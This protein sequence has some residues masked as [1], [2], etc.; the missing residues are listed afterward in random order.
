MWDTADAGFE[1]NLAARAYFALHGTLAAPR[2]ATALDKPVGQWLTN[3]RRSGGLGK[4]PS[5]AR[6]RADQLTQVDP[7]SR[8]R[9]DGGLAAPPRLPDPAPRRRC[10]ARGCGAGGD[11][12]RRGRRTLPHHPAAGLEPAERRAAAA[13]RRAG[14]RTGCAG[15]EDPDE[16]GHDVRGRAGAARPSR[17]AWKP[18]SSTSRGKAACPAELYCRCGARRGAARPG[19]GRAGPPRQPRPASRGGRRGPPPGPGETFGASG[20]V[21]RLSSRPAAASSTTAAVL[22]DT[23]HRASAAPRRSD[24]D[25]AEAGSVGRP[26]RT[27][28]AST[29]STVARDHPPSPASGAGTAPVCTAH[30]HAARETRSRFAACPASYS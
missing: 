6:R 28:S 30:R 5:R 25:H 16:D 20:S 8:A 19:P 9:V 10:A 26:A 13:P 29:A 24:A 1:E 27:A 22:T 14:C 4:N 12:A 18:S 3:V 23:S 2:H 21:D 7:D 15:T 11:P 17:K